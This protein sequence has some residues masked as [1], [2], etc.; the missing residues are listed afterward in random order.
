[1]FQL[2]ATSEPG[3]ALDAVARRYRLENGNSL[4]E[5][6]EVTMDILNSFYLK[7][8]NA[9]K[10]TH[11]QNIAKNLLNTWNV[12]WDL[13]F[14]FHGVYSYLRIVVHSLLYLKYTYFTYLSLNILYQL[15]KHLANFSKSIHK[16]LL[17]LFLSWNSRRPMLQFREHTTCI[18][19]ICILK[20]K[21]KTLLEDCRICP[22]EPGR[23]L[24]AWV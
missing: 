21:H 16:H 22:T 2:S 11:N 3:G 7:T 23:E 4:G 15:D 6:D 12:Y 14:S 20:I 19:K 24:K 13:S 9:F 17:D 8:L 10:C 1:M 18:N 5:K